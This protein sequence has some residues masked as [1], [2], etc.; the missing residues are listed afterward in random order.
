MSDQHFISKVS[1]F[2]SIYDF[3]GSG[4]INRPEFFISMKTMFSGLSRIF[5][6]ANTPSMIQLE[7]STVEVFDNMDKDRSGHATLDEVLTWAYRSR[8]LQHVLSPFTSKSTEMFE[9]PISFH[10]VGSELS[11]EAERYQKF[12]L[13]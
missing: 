2:F 9:E 12:C 3:N 13:S 10:T 6:D 4:S 8:P 7:E 1:F 5:A 11:L